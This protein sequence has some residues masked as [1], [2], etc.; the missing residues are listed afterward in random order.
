MNVS[1]VPPGESRFSKCC[2]RLHTYVW[3]SGTGVFAPCTE[4]KGSGLTA[5]AICGLEFK[6]PKSIYKH[7]KSKHGAFICQKKTKTCDPFSKGDTANAVI[8]YRVVD[9]LGAYVSRL[10]ESDAV[11]AF[12]EQVEIGA[13]EPMPKVLFRK[14]ILKVFG[15]FIIKLV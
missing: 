8:G 11:I 13:D 1:D 10:V 9:A 2:T 3:K 6:N 5:C 7:L 14:G 12:V 15:H 4:V